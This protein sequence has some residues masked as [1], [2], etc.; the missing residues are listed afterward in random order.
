MVLPF[1][2]AGA[3]G[4]GGGLLMSKNKADEAENLQY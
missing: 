2:L 4:L 1:L 3:L